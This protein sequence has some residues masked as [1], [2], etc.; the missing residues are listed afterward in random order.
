MRAASVIAALASFQCAVG[1]AGVYHFSS[2]TGEEFDQPGRINHGF[3]YSGVSAALT[4]A[5]CADPAVP[6]ELLP[7]IQAAIDLWNSGATAVPNCVG[8]CAVCL[9]PVPR[10]TGPV[11][12]TYV[13][14][15][16]LGHCMLGLDHTNNHSPDGTYLGGSDFTAAYQEAAFSAGSDGV[17]GTYDDLPSPLPGTRVVHW[18]R[19]GLNDPFLPVPASIDNTNYT[20]VIQDLPPAPHHWPTN[21]N[22]VSSFWL[23]HESSQS[24]MFALGA[25]R[26]SITALLPDDVNTILYARAGLDEVI[27]ADDYTYTAELVGSCADA[28]VKVEMAD[29]LGSAFGDCTPFYVPLPIEGQPVVR[30]YALDSDVQPARLRLNSTIEWTFQFILWDDFEIGDT[31]YWT[32]TVPPLPRL[33][34]GSGSGSQ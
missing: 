9:D 28:D 26:T 21:A 24:V 11:D 15:H 25:R 16:E 7:E 4:V 17:A 30:H 1:S 33:S 18:F 19:T 3:G 12:A 22:R 20:R 34:R 6:A 31:R 8:F 2:W 29:T 13:L 5:V 14:T 27:G 10:S 32:E 23:G